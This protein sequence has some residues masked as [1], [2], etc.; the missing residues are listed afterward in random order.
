MIL[1]LQPYDDVP[2]CDE[3]V[4]FCSALEKNLG[5]ITDAWYCIFFSKLDGDV[6]SE[7]VLRK[8]KKI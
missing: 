3:K 4:L 7:T 2:L 8:D 5:K 6:K 1:F